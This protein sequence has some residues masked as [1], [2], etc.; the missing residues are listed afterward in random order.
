VLTS[1]AFDIEDDTQVLTFRVM[2]ESGGADQY[3]AYLL[4]GPSFGTSTQLA[5]TT[6][7]DGAWTT[8]RVNPATWRGETVKLKLD[9]YAGTVGVDLVGVQ[10]VELVDWE[11]TG[12]ISRLTGGGPDGWFAEASGDLTSAAFDLPADAQNLTLRYKAGQAGA[13]FTV[14][15]RYGENFASAVN[16]SG[17]TV[18]GSTTEWKTFTAG[19]AGLAGEPVQLVLDGNPWRSQ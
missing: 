7:A 9:R 1:A 4:S 11:T 13:S 12:T 17:A 3:R 14:S 19:V 15:L 5:F 16:L 10:L 2:G 6:A 8:V 18:S